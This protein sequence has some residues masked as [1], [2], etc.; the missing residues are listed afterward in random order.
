MW[1]AIDPPLR[2]QPPTCTSLLAVGHSVPAAGGLHRREGIKEEVNEGEELHLCH[3]GA[4][5]TYGVEGLF[6]DGAVWVSV[7]HTPGK[8][9][10]KLTGS[11]GWTWGKR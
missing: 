1:M 5:T 3:S 8:N 9:P 2:F 7:T 11:S 4:V 10:G 6:S